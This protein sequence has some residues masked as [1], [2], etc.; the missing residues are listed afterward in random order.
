MKSI[1]IISN[2]KVVIVNVVNPYVVVVVVVVVHDHLHDLITLITS[3][4]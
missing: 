1:K 4:H 3:I 2:L